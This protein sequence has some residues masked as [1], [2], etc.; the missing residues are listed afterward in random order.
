MG[1]ACPVGRV[2]SGAREEKPLR[3]SASPTANP[4]DRTSAWP[5]IV[6]KAGPSPSQHQIIDQSSLSIRRWAGPVQRKKMLVAS[7]RRN[8]GGCPRA[9]RPILSKELH[10]LDQSPPAGWLR[11]RL[12][13]SN[14]LY[15]PIPNLDAFVGGSYPEKKGVGGSLEEKPLRE[16]RE[17]NGQSYQKNFIRSANHR[18][19]TGPFLPTTDIDQS[20]PSSYRATANPVKKTSSA[21]PIIVSRPALYPPTTDID[22]SPSSLRRWAGP[23]RNTVG[24]LPEEKQLRMSVR[25]MAGQGDGWL[26]PRA[27]GGPLLRTVEMHAGGEPLRVVPPGGLAAVAPW[28]TAS[29]ELPLLARRRRLLDSPELDAVRRLLMHE[30]RGHRDM[31]GAVLVP[32]ELPE[33][34]VGALF[35][36]NEGASSMCGHAVLCLARFAL[37]YGLCPP[38]PSPGA[39]AALTIHCPCG[40]IAAFASWDGQRSGSRTRFHSVPAFA[41][42]TDVSINVPGYGKI[43]ADVGYGGAFYAFLSADQLGLDVSSSKIRDLVDAAS[44][45]TEAVKA[46]FKVHHPLIEDVAFIYG[47]I[48]TDGKDE[49]S[50]EPTSNICVFADAQVDRSPTGSGVTA[51]I[52]LQYHK[53]LIQ[54]NQTR[55]FR[56]SSTGSL[57]TGKAIKASSKLL[58]DLEIVVVVVFLPIFNLGFQAGQAYAIKQFYILPSYFLLNQETKC[59]DHNAV[60]VEVAG[61]SFY[62]GTSTFTFEE[63]DPLKYGF[64]LK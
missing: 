30:P 37:D 28:L 52:A 39:E 16:G 60:I 40:P 64:L 2:V 43:V 32:S 21:Q 63:E 22:Q 59:G 20:P 38:P 29:S 51:R 50:D 17:R 11:A 1:G 48:L 62:T 13:S 47:T 14:H 34:S 41:A 35:V 10:P 5:I 44:S 15:R 55:T 27:P 23:G 7:V 53:G 46:Q 18:Q 45:V 61:E 57:F 26:P 24:G 33:A 36:H 56:S 4:L 25:A 12:F 6:S 58:W 3:T 49:F 42:A 9:R 31:Y 54:L 19:Q 8:C